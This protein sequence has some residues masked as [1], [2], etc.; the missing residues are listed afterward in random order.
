MLGDSQLAMLIDQ[1]GVWRMPNGWQV[2]IRAEWC[3]ITTGRPYGLSYALILQDERGQ[4]LL[5]FDNSH[6]YDGAGDDDP[7]DHEHRF[8]SVGQRFRYDF[9][10]PGELLT[11]F[12]DRVQRVCEVK[13]VPFEFEERE[14]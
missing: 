13:N 4:R 9:K 14:P 8:G 6:G 3:D 1:A 7:F 10:S 12:F 11:D 2:V 5:G